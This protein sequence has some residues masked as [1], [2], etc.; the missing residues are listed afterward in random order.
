MDIFGLQ[1]CKKGDFNAIYRGVD[2]VLK[3]H[4]IIPGGTSK[5]IARQ[6]IAHALQKM[7]K[8]DSMFDVCTITDACKIA[9]IKLSSERRDIYSLAHCICW[10]DM[11][12]DYKEMLIAMVMDDFR[13]LFLEAND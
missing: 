9:C 4:E 5:N 7:I 11:T 10:G 1:I 13:E 3:K 6:S 2:D 8:R 12:S